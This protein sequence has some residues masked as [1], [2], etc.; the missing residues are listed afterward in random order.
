[1]QIASSEWTADWFWSLPLIAFTLAVHAF[2]LVVIGVVVLRGYGVMVG[3]AESSSVRLI[4]GAT[5]T[6]A[7]VGMALAVLHGL[8]SFLW[9]VVYLALGAFD[10]LHDAMLFSLDSMTTRGASGLS[11]APHW[12][13]MGAIEAACGVLAFGASTA[14]LFAAIQAIWRALR[15]SPRVP[16]LPDETD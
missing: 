11:P 14:F 10:S 3:K 7:W 2:G 13:L 5:A 1:M 12:R 6:I 8:E 15:K 4:A 16:W 9:A